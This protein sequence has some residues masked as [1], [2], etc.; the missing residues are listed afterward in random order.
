MKAWVLQPAAAPA[1]PAGEAG[2]HR[3]GRAVLIA[4]LIAAVA[5]GL[6]LGGHAGAMQS[7]P[8][9]S[10]EP[11]LAL[12][13]RFMGLV[14]L[15]VAAG[16]TALLYWRLRYPMTAPVRRVAIIS[17]WCLAAGAAMLVQ[18]AYLVPAAL[19]FHLGLAA[20]LILAWRE[21]RHD[22]RLAPPGQ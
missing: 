10:G 15:G 8:A 1:E 17:T 7:S 18:L 6:W 22:S 4:G 21:G 12:L 13:L 2:R 14:K 9:F 19:V 11:A 16:A 5:G 3:R 20:L